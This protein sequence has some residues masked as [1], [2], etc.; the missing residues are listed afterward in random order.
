MFN[1]LI[2]SIIK[3]GDSTALQSLFAEHPN[4]LNLH[5]RDE[6]GQTPLHLAVS[7][8]DHYMVSLLVSRGADLDARDRGGM[9]PVALAQQI[10]NLAIVSILSADPL[11]FDASNNVDGYSSDANSSDGDDDIFVVGE[12]II[13]EISL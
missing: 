2:F 8:E 1:K 3:S 11:S 9:T 10:Q 7:H 5:V 13:N 6:F 12:T 4:L